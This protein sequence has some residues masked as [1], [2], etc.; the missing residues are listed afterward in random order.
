MQ[1]EGQFRTKRHPRCPECRYNL[2]ATVDAGIRTCPECGC[3]FDLD[4]LHGE[5]RPGE[6]TP[7]LGLRS[8]ALHL[9]GKMLI[10]LPIWTALIWLFSPLLIMVPQQGII[11][12]RM[13]GGVAIVCVIPGMAIGYALSRDLEEKA[14]F[15]SL[16]LTMMASLAAAG[17]VA[18]GLGLSHLLRP[19][20]GWVV[21]FIFIATTAFALGW[22]VR[23]TLVDG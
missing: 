2:V 23:Q 1:P 15:Q 6:W 10:V 18:G 14:G 17:T 7:L 22:I 13:F 8:A 16:L 12:W 4:E 3:E 5:K 9:A 20:G 19:V 11:I 21:T